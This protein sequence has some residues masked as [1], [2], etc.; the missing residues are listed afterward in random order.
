MFTGIIQKIGKCIIEKPYL[1]LNIN[2]IKEL[3]SNYNLIIGNSIAINGVCLT[4]IKYDDSYVYFFIMEETFNKTNFKF[5]DNNIEYNVN[6]EPALKSS[7]ELG[8][9]IV[10]GH[11]HNIAKLINIID[12]SDLS[13]KYTFKFEDND[14][15]NR[16]KYKDSITIDGVSLT[17][18]ELTDTTFSVCL[19]PH[20]LNNTILGD[21]KID[22]NV[23][24][25][26]NLKDDK[27]PTDDDY[28][29]LAYKESLKGR[30]TA[31]P[32]PWVGCVI[33]YY[34][35]IIGRGYH[36]KSGDNHAE[37]NAI[38]ECIQNGYEDLLAQST[39][40]STLE[41]CVHYGKTGPCVDEIIKRGFKRVVIGI[42]DKDIRVSGKSKTILESNNIKVDYISESTSLIIEE[43]L[44]SY[45][46]HRKYNKPYCILKTALSLDGYSC[47]NNGNSQW[48]TSLKSRE[49][50]HNYRAKSQAIIIG[51][52]TVKKDNPILNAR[53]CTEKDYNNPLIV[54]ID[55]KGIINN[56]NIIENKPILILTSK[57]VNEN[58]LNVWK[59][60][61]HT[62]IYGNLNYLLEYL[63][64]QG[65]L[66][67]II[68]GG[69]T[70]QSIFL[71]ENLI[72]ELHIYK[73]N[74]FIGSNGKNYLNHLN[75]NNINDCKRYNLKETILLDND[76]FI[77]YKVN[78]EDYLNDVV[79]P[80]FKNG[81]MVI[82]MDDTHREDEGDIV[83]A[84]EHITPEKI[85]FLKNNT[86]GIICISM[87]ERNANRLGI[88]RFENNDI[89]QTPFGMS[90]D[91]TGCKTG[92]SSYER[93]LTI[94]K[95]TELDINS[96]DFTRPGHIFPLISCLSG[97]SQRRGHT[98]A[99]VD[100]CKISG[101]LPMAVI[102]ELVDNSGVMMRTDECREFAKIHNIPFVSVSDI[103]RWIN[104]HG[105]IKPLSSTPIQLKNLGEWTLIC[106]NSFDESNPHKVLVKGSVWDKS[107]IL[108]RI[109]S[110]CF[111]GDVLN[112]LMCDCGEQLNKSLE[113]INNE[114]LGMIIFP[115]K[116]EGRGIGLIN[117]LKAYKKIHESKGKIDTY[118]A[119][120]LLGYDDD[121][122]D[123][124]IV[125]KI[126]D[127]FGLKSIILLTNNI[128]KYDYIKEYVN[129][130]KIIDGNKNEFN[131]NYL[132]S[133]SKY[134]IIKNE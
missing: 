96:N 123:Y 93:Y 22:S 21:Y 8:G 103:D 53:L 64:K 63:G 79:I 29:L 7:D 109:H 57:K 59:N 47:L 75:I 95:M 78:K 27:I 24:I 83:I 68:E 26:Y 90:L 122:R 131:N 49:H 66:Q 43:S 85:T 1:K 55:S 129:E 133:K 125:G 119:N 31:P 134:S 54:L 127:D 52:N 84:A 106:Y 2:S 10:Q 97:I 94:K 107:N 15:I 4:I 121:L 124:N 37:I 56:G 45:I 39:L 34:D 67:C 110:E 104:T 18:S 61:G 89:N 32:N 51:S 73:G 30:Y 70:L 108:V 117:K 88:K 130:I 50:A 9:H 11:V 87:D 5:L 99:S 72:D 33:V 113:L 112:S 25:E 118:Q 82:I 116:H 36:K 23:N 92:V 62:V 16:L 105:I 40:Y 120:N 20:T 17:I 100:L 46:Y 42:Q 3:L 114:G 102:G 41:P 69:Q 13:R 19:I 60:Y 126:L 28:M 35:K 14:S 132:K 80:R 115:A 38:N 58:T 76:I 71:K 86:T 65:I 81:D 6:V 74:V 44:R 77:K 98:E 111:T 48:I 101:L 91:Y 12:N 128:N